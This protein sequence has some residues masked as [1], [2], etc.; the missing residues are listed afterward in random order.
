MKPNSQLLHNL[1]DREND[2]IAKSYI[3]VESTKFDELIASEFS[4]G[5]SYFYI[6]DFFDRKIKYMS[7]LIEEIHGL[8]PSTATFQDIL[9]QIHP[10]DMPFVTKAEA[11]AFDIFYNKLGK[12]KRKKY[13]ISY[14]FRFKIKDGTYQ[15]FNHQAIILSLDVN[16][17]LSKSLNIHTNIS[18]LTKDNNYKVSAIGMFG[19]PSFLNLAPDEISVLP[20]AT[21]PLFSKREIEIIRLVSDGYNN[22]DIAKM[23]F[24]AENTVKTHRKNISKKS[25]CKNSVQLIKKAIIVGLI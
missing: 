19:E 24:I 10:E 22:S 21:S 12:E 4:S 20:E 8:D 16:G 14:C 18:H 15:L 1:W 6:V 25:G 7:P 9:D 3:V 17:G 13:K 11:M 5:P 2:K 23:L